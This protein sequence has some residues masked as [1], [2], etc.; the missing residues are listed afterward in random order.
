MAI[1]DTVSS[2]AGTFAFRD[3][4]AVSRYLDKHRFLIPLLWEVDAKIR[5]YFDVHSPVILEVVKDFESG[6]DEDDE[7]FAMVPTTLPPESAIE[8]LWRLDE[9]WWLGASGRGRHRMNIGIEY[10]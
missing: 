8:L 2:L 5:Q 4:Q 10:I 1:Q 3:E 6:S 9:D 7:L